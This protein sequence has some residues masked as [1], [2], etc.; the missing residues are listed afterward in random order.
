PVQSAHVVRKKGL[1]RLGIFLQEFVGQHLEDHR[2][3]AERIAAGEKGT[4]ITFANLRVHEW[5]DQDAAVDALFAYGGRLIGKRHLDDGQILARIDAIF[6]KLNAQRKID[7]RT[8]RVDADLLAFEILRGGY[9]RVLQ[10]EKRILR[11]AGPTIL[12]VIR[13]DAHTVRHDV[14]ENGGGEDGKRQRGHVGLTGGE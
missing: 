13:D 11:I 10:H 8:K 7:R 2:I 12:I 3:G 4:Q 1:H 14:L 5:Q 6:L 9:R